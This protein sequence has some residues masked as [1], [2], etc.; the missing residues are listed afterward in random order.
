MTD[1]SI[2]IYA[3]INIA[4]AGPHSTADADQINNVMI[5]QSAIQIAGIGGYGGHGNHASGGDVAMHILS[6]LHLIG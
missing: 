1:V 5:D 3:P 6:D 4:I 2:A